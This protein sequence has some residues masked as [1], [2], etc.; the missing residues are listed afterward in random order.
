MPP[1]ARK[2]VYW[3]MHLVNLSSMI[4]V[5]IFTVEI[6]VGQAVSTIPFHDPTMMSLEELVH[7]EEL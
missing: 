7:E 3:G 6:E 4:E 5:N 1:L 2:L